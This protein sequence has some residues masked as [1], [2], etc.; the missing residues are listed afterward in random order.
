MGDPH[1]GGEGGGGGA[2]SV[3]VFGCHMHRK[4]PQINITVYRIQCVHGMGHSTKLFLCFSV[5]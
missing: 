4:R 5:S 1:E 2:R 3:C